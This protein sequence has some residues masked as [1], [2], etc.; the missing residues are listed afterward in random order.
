MLRNSDLILSISESGWRTTSRSDP[1]SL[2]RIDCFLCLEDLMRYQRNFWVT[3][4]DRNYLQDAAFAF[5]G[6]N[7]LLKKMRQDLEPAPTCKAI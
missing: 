3:S 6:E 5:I 2:L 4:V 7:P 1:I